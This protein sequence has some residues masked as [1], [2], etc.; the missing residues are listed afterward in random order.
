[1]RDALLLVIGFLCSACGMALLA[2][3]MKAH[4]QQAREQDGP[5]RSAAFKLRVI[6]GLALV[7]SLWL[8]LQVDH[9]SMAALV[10]VMSLTAS[11]LIVSFTLNW[12]P[13]LLGWLVAW[14]R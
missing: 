8:C 12:R 9:V 11:A 2:L 13:R 3:A 5:S 1:M 14:A 6:G 7:V 4:W 10:W